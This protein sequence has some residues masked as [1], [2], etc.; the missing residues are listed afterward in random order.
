MKLR[1]N[2]IGLLLLATTILWAAIPTGYYT[3]ANGK[4]TTSLHTTMETIISNGYVTNSYDKLYIIYQTSDVIPG[5]N[6]IWDTYSNCTYVAN[7]STQRCGD[8]TNVCDCYNREH[9]V[10]QS[11]FNSNSPMVSDAFH[12]YPTDGKVN[13]QRNNYPYG[14]CSSG[15]TLT[16]GRGKLGNSTFSGYSGTVFEPDDEFKGD[17][18]RTYFYMATRYASICSSW[19]NGVFSTSNFGLTSYAV[20]LFLKW[21]RQDPV[22]QKEITRNDA[23]YAHQ[24]N[25][26]PYIDFPGLEEYILG[27]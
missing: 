23:I 18:A 27:K 14:E 16:G 2:F 10:P 21:S 12:I 9:S 8:Y 5:T 25:R 15:V 20:N 1:L 11:W 17:F 24:N 19:G 26:N 22:S 3:N 6:Y 7:T 13:G 4:N